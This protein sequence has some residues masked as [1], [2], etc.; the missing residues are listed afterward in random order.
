MEAQDIV[1]C[2]GHPLVL[3]SHPTTFEI[4]REDHLSTQGNCIVGIGADKGCND[5][6]PAF[7]QVVAHDDAI[8]ITRLSCGGI[9]AEIS[10]RG[11]SLMSLDHPTDMVWRRSTFVCG[12]TIGILSDFV[13]ETLPRALIMN[14]IKGNT[15]T[16]CLT[17]RRPGKGL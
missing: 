14:L 12:R 9:T 17:A 2:R 6:S 8:L 4:T 13:A 5:L 1:Y 11:S 15:M 16:V 10:S 7:K 3:G